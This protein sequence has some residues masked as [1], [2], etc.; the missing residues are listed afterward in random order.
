MTANTADL[1]PNLGIGRFDVDAATEEQL[2][3]YL[4]KVQAAIE[5]AAV[6]YGLRW[7]TSPAS[8]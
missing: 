8:S 5:A 3:D 7:D 6:R 1:A 4:T 2:R